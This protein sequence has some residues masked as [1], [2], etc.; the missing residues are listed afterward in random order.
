MY[1]YLSI[2]QPLLSTGFPPGMGNICKH[3]ITHGCRLGSSCKFLHITPDELAIK[4]SQERN[5]HHNKSF[6]QSGSTGDP[7]QRSSDSNQTTVIN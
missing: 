5:E 1:V 3:Y 4:M 2:Y 6:S 7:S